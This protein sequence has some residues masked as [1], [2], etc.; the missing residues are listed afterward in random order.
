MATPER[1]NPVPYLSFR[2][3]SG[4]LVINPHG[5]AQYVVRRVAVI[6]PLPPTAQGKI[7]RTILGEWLIDVIEYVVQVRAFAKEERMTGAVAYI[8]QARRAVL[9][10]N[11]I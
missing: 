7:V 4:R 3:Q 2:G 1:T 10:E 5:C 8:F 9:E 6:G 11:A